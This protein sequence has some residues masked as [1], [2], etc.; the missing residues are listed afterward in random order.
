MN[1]Q[2]VI[3]D[4]ETGARSILGGFLEKLDFVQLSSSFNNAIEA[5]HYLKMNPVD[6]LLLDINM[7]EVSGFGLLDML[8]S[9]PAVIFT[10][11]YS[12]Y[13]VQGFDYDAVDFLQKP[14]RLERF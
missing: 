4:D 10:S 8:D 12:N 7:P 3:V 2:C 11:A 14:I 13:A 1:L 6:I 5:F 9:K